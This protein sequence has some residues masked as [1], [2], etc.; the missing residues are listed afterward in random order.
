MGSGPDNAGTGRYCQTVRVRQARR[1][2]ATLVNQWLNPLKRGTGS[3]LVNRGRAAV[4][5]TAGRPGVV[6]SKPDCIAGGEATGK[7][8]G[9]P[10]ARLQGHS[11][12]SIPPTGLEVNVGTVSGCPPR[13]LAGATVGRPTAG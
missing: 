5:I 2:G 1:T 8:C 13:C 11:W 9:V 3:N 6:T 7:V 4:H 10:V 12:A